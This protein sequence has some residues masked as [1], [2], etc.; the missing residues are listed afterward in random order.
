MAKL[1][2]NETKELGKIQEEIYGHFAEHLGRCIYEGLYVGE[3]SVIPNKNGMRVDVVEA[4]KLIM[5]RGI[6]GKTYYVGV[7][8]GAP[9]KLL[10]DIIIDVCGGCVEIINSPI[11]H[12][13]VGI[14]DFWCDNNELLSLGWSPK[15]SIRDGIKETA[16]KIKKEL[17]LE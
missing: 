12:K 17:N 15:V 2:V 10:V 13:Q 5:E 3:D 6:S 1:V 9:M 14:D 7:G 16:D 8:N 11:F 4:L